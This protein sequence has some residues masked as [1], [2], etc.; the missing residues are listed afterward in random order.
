MTL[1]SSIFR[2]SLFCIFFQFF[3]KKGRNCHNWLC[4]ASHLI[5]FYG[6]PRWWLWLRWWPR[7]LFWTMISGNSGKVKCQAAR[8]LCFFVPLQWSEWCSTKR[9][10]AFTFPKHIQT[11]GL[12]DM[13]PTHDGHKGVSVVLLTLNKILIV[14]PQSYPASLHICSND[15]KS[16][17]MKS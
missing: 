6:W 3:I 10:S 2:Y 4:A 5:A 13:W 12:S 16:H 15:L 9:I 8:F 17:S 14:V 1:F 7:L 11:D